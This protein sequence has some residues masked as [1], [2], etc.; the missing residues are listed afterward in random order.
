[1]K[2]I[3]FIDQVLNGGGAERVLCT[4]MRALNNEKYKIYLLLITDVGELGKLIPHYVKTDVL[5]IDKTRKSILAV[6]KKIRIIRPDIVYVTTARTALLTSI[7][8]FFCPNFKFV[9]RF[10]TMPRRYFEERLASYCQV[11][12]MCILYSQADV[13]IA[14]TQE[15]AKELEQYFFIDK[16]KIKVLYNPVDYKLIDK[17]LVCAE[18]PFQSGFINI[19]ASGRLDPVKCYDVLL[20]A[21]ANVLICNNRFRLYILGSNESNNRQYL[22][23]LCCELS[24]EKYVRFLGFIGNPY[25]YYKF[26]DLFVLSSKVEGFPNVILELM[27]LEKPIISTKCA[28]VVENLIDNGH[29]GFLV[30]I[31]NENAL[32]EAIL[33]Y[34]KIVPKKKIISKN[35]IVELIDSL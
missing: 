30:E 10:P 34:D 3:L 26:C 4:T 19:V 28:H 7:C 17:S 22:E 1:M 23:S 21:F 25:P 11:R 13:V 6:I 16:N 9:L 15:M 20:K 33:K 12:A 8:K 35:A 31:N 18:N 14:Q 2:K 32:C 5:K 27:Y 24:I 29:N